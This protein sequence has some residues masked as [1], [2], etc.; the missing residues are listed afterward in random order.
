MKKIFILL[1]LIIFLTPSALAEEGDTLFD[2]ITDF[3]KYSKYDA[4][5]IDEQEINKAIEKVKN[6]HKSKKQLI[7]EKA[8]KGAVLSDGLSGILKEPY[9]LLQLPVDIYNDG[10]LVKKGFYKTVFLE[11]DNS[12]LLKQGYKVV[13]H[14]KMNKAKQELDT[15]ELYY[16]DAS[17]ANGYLKIMYGA[18]DRH[19]ENYFKIAN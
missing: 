1:F 7:K 4:K 13:T 11:K 3:D 18:M 8:Q 19:L 10:A 6:L 5:P 17:R 2:S 9:L 14:M 16:I 15:D 12:I